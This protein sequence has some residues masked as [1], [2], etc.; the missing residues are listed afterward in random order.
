MNEIKKQLDALGHQSISPLLENSDDLHKEVTVEEKEAAIRT[1][2]GN[3]ASADCIL[4]YNPEKKGIQNYIGAN[5]LIEIGLSF[6]LRK[7][8]YI[9][10][11]LPEL[12]YKDE[13]EAMRPILLN[14]DLTRIQ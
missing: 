3:I 5:T 8:I 4:I 7:P 6:Y 14:G 11:G 1:H 12:S 2:F 13:I 10:N 9:Y